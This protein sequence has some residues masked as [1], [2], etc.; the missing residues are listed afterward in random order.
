MFLPDVPT[1]RE[2]GLDVIGG[3]N[4]IVAAPKGVPADALAK[5]R[6]CYETVFK[7]PDFL[8][9]AK[10]RSIPVFFMSGADTEAYVRPA[11][12]HARRAVEDQSLGRELIAWTADRRMF[13]GDPSA[14]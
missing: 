2:L 14:A 8:A 4:Q 10:K 9:D 3:S 12:G 6:G 5:L 7:D 1:M 11:D 13:F